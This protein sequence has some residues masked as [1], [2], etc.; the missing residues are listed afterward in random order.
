MYEKRKFYIE[1]A[2]GNLQTKVRRKKME[3]RK[4]DWQ[5][6]STREKRNRKTKHK[7]KG[8]KIF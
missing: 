7:M 5:L 6:K 2:A 4:K 8:V 3:E 1:Y